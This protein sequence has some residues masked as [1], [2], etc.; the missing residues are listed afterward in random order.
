MTCQDWVISRRLEINETNAIS[1][2]TIISHVTIEEEPNTVSALSTIQILTAD[3]LRIRIS[4]LP[5]TDPE[6]K[7]EI[8]EKFFPNCS[9]DLF[10]LDNWKLKA[11]INWRTRQIMSLKVTPSLHLQ[12]GQ[13]IRVPV[14]LYTDG[15][16]SICTSI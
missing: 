4:S 15:S 12:G 1:Q 8:V 11:T 14:V 16:L 7:R 10:D 2:T 6:T 9:L 5:D 3:T 13:Q